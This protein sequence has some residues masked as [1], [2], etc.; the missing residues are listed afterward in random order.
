ML[1]NRCRPLADGQCL[2]S[3]FNASA[4]DRS[5]QRESPE[6]LGMTH[7]LITALVESKHGT[8]VKITGDD[9]HANGAPDR[10]PPQY[11]NMTFAYCLYLRI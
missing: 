3:S 2:R 10:M 11:E 4:G 7:H 6:Q 8:V 9:V 1:S 5:E